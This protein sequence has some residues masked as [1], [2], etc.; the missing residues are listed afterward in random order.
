MCP[1]INEVGGGGGERQVSII[2]TVW[3]SYFVF[4][5][6]ISNIIL[7]SGLEHFDIHSFQKKPFFG[8]KSFLMNPG[9]LKT[10]L[11]IFVLKPALY[12]SMFLSLDRLYIPKNVQ[13]QYFISIFQSKRVTDIYLS[14]EYSQ[15][16][17]FTKTKLL[18]YFHFNYYY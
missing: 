6:V 5:S 15:S 3:N 13:T 18:N 2:C 16:P 4:L 10:Y 7:K 1:K 12:K 8:I 17:S 14:N 11:F 9:Y